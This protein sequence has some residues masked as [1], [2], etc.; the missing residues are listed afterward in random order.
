MEASTTAR[1]TQGP[2]LLSL[3]HV[4]SFQACV[5]NACHGRASAW[6]KPASL[7]DR[8]LAQGVQQFHVWI[9]LRGCWRSSMPQRSMLGSLT[10]RGGVFRGSR[11]YVLCQVDAHHGPR[12]T[13][14]LLI[15]FISA[16]VSA[17][18]QK[19]RPFLQGARLPR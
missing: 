12:L 4:L 14:C 17:A 6:V 1:H 16:G 18:T 11:C 19:T 10:A 8:P 9:D 15:Y 7:R 13:A 5:V 3:I 2:R